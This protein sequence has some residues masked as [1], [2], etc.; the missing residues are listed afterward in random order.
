VGVIVATDGCDEFQ[1]TMF[2][3]SWVLPSAKLP[4]ADNCI[5]KPIGNEGLGG[6]IEMDDNCD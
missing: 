5:V 3:K 1:V 6:V 4:V 2:V